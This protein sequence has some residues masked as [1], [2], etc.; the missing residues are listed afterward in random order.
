MKISLLSQ[1]VKEKEEKKGEGTADRDTG[2][3]RFKE[4]KP[5]LLKQQRCVT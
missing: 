1:N 5:S 2:S 4:G 3:K